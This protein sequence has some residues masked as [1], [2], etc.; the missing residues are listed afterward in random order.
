MMRNKGMVH[1]FLRIRGRLHGEIL[2]RVPK[3]HINGF[4]LLNTSMP[5]HTLRPTILVL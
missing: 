3:N 2:A 4:A 5:S 1:I